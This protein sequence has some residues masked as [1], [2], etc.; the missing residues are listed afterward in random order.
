MLSISYDLS[1]VKLAEA[2]ADQT[3]FRRLCGFAVDKPTPERTTFVRFRRELSRGPRSGAVRGGD[4]QLEAQGVV[5][6]TGT[7]VDATL[8]PSA[9]IKAEQKAG[10]TG[11]RRKKPIHGYKV[12]VATDEAARLV[13]A[14][15]ITTANAHDGTRLEVAA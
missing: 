13:R 1:D 15:E 9:S 6:R 14:V 7:L 4:R 10:W 2:L 11:H 3:S 5:V 8:I 12:Q